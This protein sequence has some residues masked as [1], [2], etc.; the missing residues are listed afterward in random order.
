MWV[1]EAFRDGS[2]ADPGRSS[3]LAAKVRIA[4]AD[5]RLPRLLAEVRLTFVTAVL[6][7]VMTFTG[8]L[9]FA[10]TAPDQQLCSWPSIAIPSRGPNI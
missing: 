7:A 4:A 8:S 3:L 10:S 2:E 6:A 5:E 1:P 9:V